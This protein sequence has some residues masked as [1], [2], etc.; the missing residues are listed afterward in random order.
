MRSN[1]SDLVLITGVGV[2]PSITL[3]PTLTFEFLVVVD[4]VIPN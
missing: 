3:L 1:T 2:G 4:V